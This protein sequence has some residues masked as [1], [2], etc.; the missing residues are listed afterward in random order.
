MT[1][2][3][4]MVRLAAP[5]GD[6]AVRPFQVDG[7]DV[8]GRAVQMGPA[9]DALLGRHDYP[10][11]V[12]KLVAE[13]AVLTALLGASLKFEGKFILQTQTD[14]PVSMLVVDFR[15][16]GDLR[17]Y[18]S[19]NAEAVAKAEAAGEASSGQL[20]GRG[21]LAMTIDQGAEMT[22]YQGIVALEGQSLEEVAHSYFRQSEQIPTKVRLA[23]AELLVRVDGETRHLWR[24]GG[25][26][27]QFMPAVTSRLPRIDLPGGDVPEGV[28]TDDTA[29][30][31]SWREAQLLVETVE[32][33][34]LLDSSVPVERLLYRLFHERGVRVYDPT[35]LREECSCNRGRIDRVLRSFS[36]E[37]IDESVEDGRIKVKCEFCGTAYEFEPGEYRRDDA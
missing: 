27:A 3:Q 18:A 32:D 19:F 14:G 2:A 21:T 25:I 8:R 36:A 33:H 16:P 7:L 1:A 31:D 37:A 11:A 22:R 17:A 5:A 23:A 20:L 13:A 24:A 15:T 6:D 10:P 34:E 4:P 29:E 12:S 35:P 28:E 26:L 9:L 30:D